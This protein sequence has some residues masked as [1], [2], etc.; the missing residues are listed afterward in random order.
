MRIIYIHYRDDSEAIPMYVC[1]C[2]R[3]SDQAIHQ[4]VAEGARS[5]RE[6]REQT[7]C[8]TQCGKCACMGKSVTQD[9]LAREMFD[10]TQLAYAV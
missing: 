2:K 10:E 4:V 8:G 5:W 1:L 3:V 6:V 7:G 9:A